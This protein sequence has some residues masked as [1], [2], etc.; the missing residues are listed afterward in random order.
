M[1]RNKTILF[2][3]DDEDDREL[4]S[5][6]INKVNSSVETIFAENG[7]HALNYLTG[8]KE[9]S[10]LPCLIVLDLNMP[11]LDG[12]ETYRK[13]KDELKLEAVPVI[14]F[15]S[16]HNPNDKKL[17]SSMGGRVYK[18]ANKFFLYG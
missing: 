18:Q 13:I 5:E 6:V 7:L 10:A 12:K 11:V 8:V 16:S 2:V 17:F 15:T 4:I 14:I 1:N 9:K 3:E